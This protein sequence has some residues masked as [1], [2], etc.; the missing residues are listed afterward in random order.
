MRTQEGEAD[1]ERAQIKWKI[2]GA[3]SGGAYIF[4][5]KYI[6]LGET[7][8]KL[9]PVGGQGLNLCW[10]DVDC[11]AKLISI[12]LLKN[13]YS[14]IPIIYS[15]FRFV[16]VRRLYYLGSGTDLCQIR[17]FYWFDK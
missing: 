17:C 3:T 11:L 7:A 4:S 15:L 9:H 6:Y 14:F 2:Q 12:P 13:Y 10:R 16:D 1:A 8:H 5:G